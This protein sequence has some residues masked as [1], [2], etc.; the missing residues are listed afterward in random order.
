MHNTEDY[1]NGMEIAAILISPLAPLNVL[2][3]PHGKAKRQKLMGMN[4]SHVF[5]DKVQVMLIEKKLHNQVKPL[6]A[7]IPMLHGF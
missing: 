3:D 1:V 4:T 7:L 2:I 6:Q 5:L